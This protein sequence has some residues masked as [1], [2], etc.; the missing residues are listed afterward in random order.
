MDDRP[1]GGNI[2]WQ[3]ID[4]AFHDETLAENPLKVQIQTAKSVP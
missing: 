4:R 1:Q 3:G 2:F